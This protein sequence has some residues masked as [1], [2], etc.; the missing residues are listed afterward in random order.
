MLKRFRVSGFMDFGEVELGFGW[1][2][3]I[4]GER[5]DWVMRVLYELVGDFGGVSRGLGMVYGLDWGSVG[6]GAEFE[7]GVY[8]G[9]TGLRVTGD[10]LVIRRA[11]RNKSIVFVSNVGTFAR[12]TANVFSAIYD[13]RIGDELTREVS[14][15]DVRIEEDGGEIYVVYEKI[16]K[17][18]PLEF[19]D[20]ESAC[21]ATLRLLIE[22]GFDGVVLIHRPE[23]WLSPQR[24]G[25]LLEMVRLLRANGNQVVLS[26]NDYAIHKEFSLAI[27]EGRFDLNEVTFHVLRRN[28][29][30]MIVSYSGSHLDVYERTPFSRKFSEL[31]MRDVVRSPA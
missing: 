17:K 27:L 3:V 13:Q 19:A 26:T 30:G 12:R 1:V 25:L 4:H 8:G 7:V 28:E 10:G 24:Y 31:F 6:V 14:D 2:D 9:V 5:L 23:G 29:D 15:C 11:P 21:L 22:R 16:G 18:I 20:D